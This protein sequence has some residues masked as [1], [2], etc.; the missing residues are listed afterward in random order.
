MLRELTADKSEKG[1]RIGNK[2][3]GRGYGNHGVG[4]IVEIADGWLGFDEGGD[5]KSGKRVRFR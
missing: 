3:R 2:R 1:L 4:A 5:E